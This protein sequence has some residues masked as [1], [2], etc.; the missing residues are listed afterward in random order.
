MIDA[1]ALAG[2]LTELAAANDTKVIRMEGGKKRVF[3][4]PIGSIMQGEQQS[5]D[6]KLRPDDTIVVPESFF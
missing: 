6:I 5:K 4:I 2:G 3:R 1:V